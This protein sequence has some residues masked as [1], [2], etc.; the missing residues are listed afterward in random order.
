MTPQPA[1]PTRTG[2][3]I[4]GAGI[5]GLA[6][7]VEMA[8]A[9]IDF[10]VLEKGST[11]GGTWRDNDYPGASCDV[12][13][14][15]YSYSY[16]RNPSWTSTYAGQAEILAY[17]RRIA[18]RR[19]LLPRMRFGTEVT[20][21]RWNADAAEW[22]VS[23]AEGTSYAAPFL[24]LGVGGLHVPR[25]PDLPGAAGFAGDAWHTARWNH[26]VDLTGKRVTLIGVGA[27][28][29]QVAPYL[30]DRAAALTIVQRSPA[31]VLPK[32]DEPITP[33]RR[34][35]FRRVPPAQSLYRLRLYL[36]REKRG[37]GFHHRP[38][39]LRV[40]EPVVARSIERHIEDPA[41][42]RL[43]TPA[44]RLGCKRVL[45][46]NDYY[47][48]LSQPHVHVVSGTPQELRPSA[49]VD[50][51][52]V[53]HQTDVLVWATGFDLRGSYDRIR[54][55]GTDGALLGERWRDGMGS[56]LGVAVAGFPNMFT[57]LGPN[58][59]VAYTSVI[60]LIETQARY[61]VRA[62]L[63]VRAA[64]ASSLEV[65]PEAEQ[66]FQD[67][68]RDRFRRTVWNV[69]ECRSWY[70]TTSESGTVLWPDSTWSYRWLLR[71]VR[72]SDYRFTVRRDH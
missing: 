35:L 34:A 67:E 20:A 72:V 44:Y 60:H 71:D 17:L 57:L 58:G 16:E 38:D 54:V 70:R 64:G 37:I 28:G 13:S 6:Q 19:G 53:E 2:A 65:R 69:G 56:Y 27:S 66:A 36:R 12:E 39:A 22:V 40:A 50:Q 46:S 8:R 49:V 14:H 15:L 62:M 45:F 10:L 24:V 11:V 41:L 33:G 68:V 59:F 55:E 30:A 4:V 7:A 23:T 47:R 3:L 52:G 43:V 29:V 1:E 9:G 26:R 31:W 51:D 32:P 61:I 18:E 48:T 5:S 63:K 42:R 25:I 21:A